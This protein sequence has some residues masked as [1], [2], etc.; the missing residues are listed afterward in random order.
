MLLR[1]AEITTTYP[2]ELEAAFEKVKNGPNT[3][4]K[5][6]LVEMFHQLELA[7]HYI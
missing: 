5:T 7:D 3:I 1:I 4:S 2:G 6:K